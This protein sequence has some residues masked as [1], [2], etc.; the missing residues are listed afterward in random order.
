MRLPAWFAM[1]VLSGVVATVAVSHGQ[2]RPDNFQ[3]SFAT[4]ARDPVGR[5]AGG[6][7]MRL[8]LAVAGK[9]YARNGARRSR[10]ISRYFSSANF[11]GH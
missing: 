5:L 10:A 6:T 4:G 1:I 8:L 11:T 2:I 7:E 3:V 9:R